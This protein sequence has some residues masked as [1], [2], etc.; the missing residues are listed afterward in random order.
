MKSLGMT[1][2]SEWL[3]RKADEEAGCNI[4]VGGL[5][6]KLANRPATSAA[7]RLAFRRLISLRRR[8]LG[9]SI[10]E[11]SQ[12]SGASLLDL[13]RAERDED[14]EP[15]PRL[16]YQLA[17]ILKLPD[18]KMMQLAGLSAANEQGFG[19]IA[20]RFAARSEPVE[21]LTPTEHEALEEFVK[22]LAE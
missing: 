5:V 6:S 1:T 17:R 10:E 8:D 3:L 16:V 13:I 12:M 7:K 11:L 21:R 18:A 20:V 15:E 2:N 22:F 19:D 14:F 9:L 4:S